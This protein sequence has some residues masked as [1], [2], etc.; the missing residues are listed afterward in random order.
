MISRRPIFRVVLA[1]GVLLAGLLVLE[2]AFGNWL[3]PNRMNRLNLLRDAAL[4][5]DARALYPEGNTRITYTR[6]RYGFRGAYTSP[7]A[8]DILTIGGSAT[9][10]RYISDDETWQEVLRRTLASQGKRVSVVNAGVD[11]QST[12]GHLRNFDWW[13]PEVPGLKPRF[14]LFY[15]GVNDFHT[16]AAYDE[17]VAGPSIWTTVRESSAFYG[18][19]LKLRGMYRALVV[20]RVGHTAVDFSAIQWTDQPRVSD[21][22]AVAREPAARYEE[23]LRLLLKRSTEAGAR[24]VCVTQAS[25]YFRVDRGGVTGVTQPIQ[26]GAAEV[27]GVDYFHLIEHFN[28][29]T[30][31]VCNQ[32]GGIALDAAGEVPWTDADFYDF[33]HNTPQGAR[34]L[35]EYLAAKLRPYL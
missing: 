15:L 9:D 7:S 1:G 8:I 30:L 17:L 26:V 14:H 21:H 2:L 34:K 29:A 32:F 19:Y 13:F 22:A 20:A 6:D 35:G 11:G 23:R 24:P 3:Q 27:N 33:I 28:R 5:Y 31:A 16:R 25:R 10:Q 18:L 4:T 12:V